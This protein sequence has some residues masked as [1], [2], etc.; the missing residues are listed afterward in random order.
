MA[1]LT[2]ELH[3]FAG[4]GGGV[5]ASLLLG[6]RIVGLV[7]RDRKRVEILKARIRDGIIPDVPIWDDATTFD[8]RPWRGVVDLVSGGIPCTP[9]SC[10]GKRR[11]AADERNL[12]PATLRIVSEV[13]PRCVFFET[14]PGMLSIRDSGGGDLGE[15]GDAPGFLGTILGP[16]AALGFDCRWTCLGAADVGAT[17]RRDRLWIY[18]ERQ[19][20]R[21]PVAEPGC[22]VADADRGGVER[23]RGASDLL[24]AHRDLES[25]ALQRERRGYAARDGRED[26][27]DADRRGRD[28][29]HERLETGYVAADARGRGARPTPIP[30]WPPG[31]DDLTAWK[32]VLATRPD[33]A[34]AIATPAQPGVRRVV[35]RVLSRVDQLGALGDAQVPVVAAAAFRALSEGY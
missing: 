15:G 31:P 35:R 21:P 20:R 16:L 28:G 22:D 4:A 11:G 34:P 12:W 27:V 10:A 3:L 17:H 19:G 7:E 24:G 33:L 6:H 25:E 2:R 5:Q 30:L 13:Q 32:R 9:F 26:V 18:G 23:R 1:A 29:L 14:V 8:G